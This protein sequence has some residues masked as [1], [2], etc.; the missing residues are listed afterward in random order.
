MFS[1]YNL[2]STL[3]TGGVGGLLATCATDSLDVRICFFLYRPDGVEGLGGALSL[4]TPDDALILGTVLEPDW[5]KQ[6]YT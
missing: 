3:P 6:K 5:R 1:V 4:T 2:R